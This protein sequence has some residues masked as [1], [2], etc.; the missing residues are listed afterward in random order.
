MKSLGIPSTVNS[1]LY[2]AT[3]V[4]LLFYLFCDEVFGTKILQVNFDY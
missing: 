3:L 1:L 4:G 2:K